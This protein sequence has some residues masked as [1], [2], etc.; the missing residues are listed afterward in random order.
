MS[1]SKPPCYDGQNF[2]TFSLEDLQR[3]HEAVKSLPHIPRVEFFKV[4]GSTDV[5]VVIDGAPAGFLTEAE[6]NLFFAGQGDDLLR[7]SRA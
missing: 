6:F 2:C 4:P 1:E 7:G 5:A 3:V